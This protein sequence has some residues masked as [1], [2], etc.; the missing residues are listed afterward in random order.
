MTP[1][2][3]LATRTAPRTLADALLPGRR[4]NS[5]ARDALLILLGSALVAACAQI[6]IPLPFTPVPITGQTFAVL[7]T[8]M[9]LGSR[10]GCL[11]MLLYLAE[12]AAGLPVFAGGAYGV[13]KFLGPTAGYLFA[14]PLAALLVGLLAEHG[15]DRKPAGAALTMLL[16]SSVILT[17][18]CLWL[19]RFV[20][21]LGTALLQG[22]LPFLPGD[23]VKVGLAA[24][25]LPGGWALVKRL[26]R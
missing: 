17:L 9:A 6:A 14:Y 16:G 19:S 18:G 21:G 15:W 22:V 23:V 8:G 1:N 11:A 10:R 13:A 3:T 7:L 12:G 4:A 20:G 25:A 2:S 26:E 5:I 24:A